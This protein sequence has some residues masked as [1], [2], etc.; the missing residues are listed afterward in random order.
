[1]IN[2]VLKGGEI[3]GSTLIGEGQIELVRGLLI[4][5]MVCVPLMLL[6]KPWVLH[7]RNVMKLREQKASRRGI[8][9]EDEEG[10]SL[11]KDKE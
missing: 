5:C 3:H 11:V 4:G 7:Q 9:D 10:I 1:M 2:N 8:R 6:V